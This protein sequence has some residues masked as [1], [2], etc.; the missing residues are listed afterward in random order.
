MENRADDDGGCSGV[1]EQ[2]GGDDIVEDLKR[3]SIYKHGIVY[4]PSHIILIS[5]I[6]VRYRLQSFSL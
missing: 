5:F 3:G 4:V 6:F 1:E 2:S